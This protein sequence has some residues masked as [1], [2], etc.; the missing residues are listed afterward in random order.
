MK[1]IVFVLSACLGILFWACSKNSS[2][3]SATGTTTMKVYLVDGPAAYDRVYLDIQ[4]VQVKASTDASEN[5]WQT[6]NIGRKGV[7]NLLDFKNGLDTVLGTVQLPAGHIS[8]LRMVL[9][10]NNSVVINGY[11]IP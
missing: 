2:S 9:G 8:Q 10:P 1:K 11:R 4:S 7:Y 6:V 5:D 3:D